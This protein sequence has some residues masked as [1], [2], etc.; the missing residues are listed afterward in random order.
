MSKSKS[1]SHGFHIKKNSQ[2]AITFASRSGIENQLKLPQ[3]MNPNVGAGVS[4]PRSKMHRNTSS[5]SSS[6]SSSQFGAS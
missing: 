6:S 4:S 2:T 5:F 3:N 1:G